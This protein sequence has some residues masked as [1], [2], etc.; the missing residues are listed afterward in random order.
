[1]A[2]TPESV[3]QRIF[4]YEEVLEKVLNELDPLF[5]LRAAAFLVP[6]RRGSLQTFLARHKD[7]FPARYR[8]DGS[9]HRRVRVIY[10]S[11]IRRIRE[12][13]LRGKL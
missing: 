2:E 13:V 1:M 6:M 10:A 8:L 3:P 5:D 7:E 12:R 9:G 4:T 11:E